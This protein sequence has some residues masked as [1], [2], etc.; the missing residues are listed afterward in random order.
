ML[1]LVRVSSRRQGP[2]EGRRGGD[3]LWTWA[4]S[5]GESGAHGK[6]GGLLGLS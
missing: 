6:Q 5:V 3:W 1:A 2:L 4:K